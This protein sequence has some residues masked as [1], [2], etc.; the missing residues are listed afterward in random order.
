MIST[1]TYRQGALHAQSSSSLSRNKIKD[2]WTERMVTGMLCFAPVY[3]H[4]PSSPTPPRSPETKSKTGK[5]IQITGMSFFVPVY[6]HRIRRYPAGLSS[7]RAWRNAGRNPTKR[8]SRPVGHPT[9]CFPGPSLGGYARGASRKRPTT[10]GR[11]GS[12]EGCPRRWTAPPPRPSSGDAR[13]ASS[14]HQMRGRGRRSGL[15]SGRRWAAAR[16]RPRGTRGWTP[17]RRCEALSWEA[18]QGLRPVE[19]LRGAGPSRLLRPND[20]HSRSRSGP[21]LEDLHFRCHRPRRCC[22]WWSPYCYWCTKPAA[23]PLDSA[24]V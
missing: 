12:A 4:R 17:G 14:S 15:G 18:R 23:R 21:H 16:R 11:R 19:E 6:L 2:L 5:L 24:H 13:T 3:L 20:S 9:R 10:P 8:G 22:C 7:W 1:S